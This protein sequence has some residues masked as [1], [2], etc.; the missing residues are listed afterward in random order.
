ML[1]Q[2]SELDDI[3]KALNEQLADLET[4]LTFT[5][6]VTDTKEVLM[7]KEKVIEKTVTILGNIEEDYNSLQ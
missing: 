1:R 4:H 6:Q 2:R 7:E 5:E 3:I